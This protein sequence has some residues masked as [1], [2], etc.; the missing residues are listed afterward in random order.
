MYSDVQSGER[1]DV[2]SGHRGNMPR[3]SRVIAASFQAQA[4][5]R[6]VAAAF[7]SFGS[8]SGCLLSV[9]EISYQHCRPVFPDAL[10]SCLA[11]LLDRV[12]H[13]VRD[14]GAE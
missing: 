7:S 6:P 12:L 3:H 10:L 13:V 5:V 9:V 2:G 8:R 4:A 11:V 1:L 14:H